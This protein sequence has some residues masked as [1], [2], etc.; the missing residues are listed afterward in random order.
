MTSAGKKRL[1]AVVAIIA[2]A[3]ALAFLA[4]GGMEENLVYYWTPN[5]LIDKGQAVIGSTIRLGGMVQEDSLDWNAE[6]MRLKFLLAESP[7]A[8]ERAVSVISSGA[9]PQMFRE[10]IGCIVEGVYDG[11]VFRS[12][13][14]MVKHSNEYQPPAEGED[15]RQ[16]YQTLVSEGSK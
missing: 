9:P 8:G 10:G 2:A 15:P 7:E 6:E 11:K 1:T 14:V 13:R 12:D 16:L 4:F 5:D 3:S